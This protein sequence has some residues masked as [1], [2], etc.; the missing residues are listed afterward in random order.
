MEAMAR[1]L[2]TD[3]RLDDLNVRV[4]RGF[5]A[6]DRRFEAVDRR[7]DSVQ[8][9]FV[10][11]RTEMRS[12]FAAVRDEMREIRSQITGMQRMMLQLFIPL[13]TTVALGFAGLILTRA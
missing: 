5:G 4:D 7:F 13:T 1:E 8:R 10:A 11:L 9:E 2:W 3:E 6:V 12:E